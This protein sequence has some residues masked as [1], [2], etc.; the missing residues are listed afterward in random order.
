[1]AIIEIRIWCSVLPDDAGIG[2]VPTRRNV[3]NSDIND[4]MLVWEVP[5]GNAAT[6]DSTQFFEWK[7]TSA[8][9]PAVSFVNSKRLQSA[10]YRNDSG[11]TQ[12]RTGVP[13]K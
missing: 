7:D 2:I 13:L 6:F 10:T 11:H 12:Q 8:G 4:Y 1:M 5:E 9:R 3:G